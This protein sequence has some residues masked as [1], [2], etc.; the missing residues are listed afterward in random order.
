MGPSSTPKSLSKFGST[1][2]SHGLSAT[3]C[4]ILHKQSSIPCPTSL[5][6]VP[7]DC[8]WPSSTR[9][10]TP[11]YP[12]TDTTTEA[13]SSHTSI[14]WHECLPGTNTSDS[15]MLSH[16]THTLLASLGKTITP[17]N[18]MT[19]LFPPKGESLYSLQWYFVF[20]DN[21][22]NNDFFTFAY[23]M[24]T[25]P[26]PVLN[27]HSPL[28]QEHHYLQKLPS[29]ISWAN[30]YDG[31]HGPLLLPW[32]HL[33]WTHDHALIFWVF[34][35]LP[36]SYCTRPSCTTHTWTPHTI[37]MGRVLSIFPTAPPHPYTMNMTTWQ[38]DSDNNNKWLA[39]HGDRDKPTSHPI[40]TSLS[41]KSEA[42]VPL[43]V[44]QSI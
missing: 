29:M 40:P 39:N 36:P 9:I 18:L 33:E 19:H 27:T 15:G 6:P 24:C 21:T 23:S 11:S 4:S 44:V 12:R 43:T 26:N 22:I 31:F 17:T 37:H 20:I 25:Y 32:S 38:H 16:A 42:E 28:H 30:G 41:N 2:M 7:H 3:L 35:H 10:W 13:H 14:Y 8:Q 34:L 1:F 5:P